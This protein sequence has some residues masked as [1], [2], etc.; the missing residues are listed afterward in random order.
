M[1]TILITGIN[2]FLGSHLAKRLSSNFKIIGLEFLLDNL[3]RLENTSFKVYATENN[4]WEEV[5]K[6]NTLRQQAEFHVIQ[7]EMDDL[8]DDIR[9]IK[10]VFQDLTRVFAGIQLEEKEI[11]KL[12]VGIMNNGHRMSK[13]QTKEANLNLKE[14]FDEMTLRENTINKLLKNEINNEAGMKAKIRDIKSTVRKMDNH[15]RRNDRFVQQILKY[16]NK[17]KETIKTAQGNMPTFGNQLVRL[18]IRF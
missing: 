3:F 17:L 16:T 6:E 7:R 13:E 10:A 8:S 4:K 14:L 9:D 2:G 5:F 12:Y 11:N 1:K 15:I 18:I